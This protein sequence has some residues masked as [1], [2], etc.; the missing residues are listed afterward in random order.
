MRSTR[1]SFVKL[2]GGAL[3]TTT[4]SARPGEAERRE[5]DLVVATVEDVA[6]SLS[7]F[8]PANPTEAAAMTPTNPPEAS[9]KAILDAVYDPGAVF[10]PET[11][12]LTPWAFEDWTVDDEHAVTATLRDGLT[13]SDGRTVTAADVAFTADYLREGFHSL[14]TGATSH[15]LNG[16]RS[17]DDL[18]DRRVRYHFDGP[19]GSWYEALRLPILPEHV[20]RSVADPQDYRPWDRG[21]PVGSGAF[22]VEAFPASDRVTLARRP[23]AADHPLL[24]EAPRLDRV[25]LRSFADESAAIRAVDRGGADAVLADVSIG[26]A[27][28][29]RSREGVDVAASPDGGWSYV[30]FNLRRTPF[31]DAAFRRT[32]AL[33]FDQQHHLARGFRD[34]RGEGDLPVSDAHSSLRGSGGDGRYDFPGEPGSP[35]DVGVVRR[36]LLDAEGSYRYTFE[37]AVSGFADAPDGR[38]LYVDGEPLVEAHTDDDHNGSQGPLTVRLPAELSG[39]TVETFRKWADDLRRVGIPADLERVPYGTLVR[40]VFHEESFDC[41]GLA[42]ESTRPTGDSL[43]ELFHSDSRDLSGVEDRFNHNAV[44]Y[45]A[46]EPLDRARSEM[47]LGRRREAFRE[48]ARR[49]YED[50]PVFVTGYHRTHQPVAADRTWVR[51]PDGVV[52]RYTFLGEDALALDSPGR[53]TGERGV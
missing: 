21:G 9:L 22:A 44:G 49:I 41:Y 1:R 15:S 10:H 37:E 6:E 40:E 46:D 45:A 25:E 17:V 52:N 26:T 39:R 30:G 36:R 28:D 16:L 4:A 19:D 53:T 35:V 23:D 42:W 48:A 29:A 34:L 47:D 32:L 3:G 7:P 50:C 27:A 38:E 20:W 13:W 8:A 5:T 2:L 18:D 11:G 31:D 24:S 51:S 33:A 12:E 14:H 43:Y